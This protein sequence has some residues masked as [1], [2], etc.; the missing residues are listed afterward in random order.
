MWS[1]GKACCRCVRR[2]YLGSVSRKHARHAHPTQTRARERE[3]ERERERAKIEPQ[4]RRMGDPH[5]GMK[6]PGHDSRQLPKVCLLDPSP[7]EQAARQE[8]EHPVQPVAPGLPLAFDLEH[9]RE[10][11]RRWSRVGGGWDGV[12]VN[13]SHVRIHPGVPPPGMSHEKS[14][15]RPATDL[16]FG[17]VPKTVVGRLAFRAA[18][19]PRPPRLAAGQVLPDIPPPPRALHLPPDSRGSG[20]G[21]CYRI[22]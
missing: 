21:S 5:L 12:R 1:G 10:K 13:S 18:A 11:S 16:R 17:V 4:H 19:V 3:R 20:M 15:C 2:P 7:P 22:K 9:G 14:R 8:H 6:Y